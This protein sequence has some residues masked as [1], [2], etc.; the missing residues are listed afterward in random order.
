MKGKKSYKEY[1]DEK[2]Y[3]EQFPCVVGFNVDR[4]GDMSI[5]SILVHVEYLDGATCQQIPV[6][7]KVTDNTATINKVRDDGKR[8][9]RVC[10]CVK[11]AVER[12]TDIPEIESVENPW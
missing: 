2:E 7:F 10:S 1:E 5:E 9:H 4:E 6:K 11:K 12:V 3:R 8:W